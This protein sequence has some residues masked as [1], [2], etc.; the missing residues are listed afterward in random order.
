[1]EA[2]CRTAGEDAMPDD[3]TNVMV[4]LERIHV[5]NDED[6]LGKG[7]LYF[8]GDVDGIPIPR[9]Q[10]FER[11]SGEDIDLS[12][13]NWQKV[14]DVRNKDSFQLMLRGR[15]EDLI[16]D[17]ELG[18]VRATIR[19]NAAGEWPDGPD[20]RTST[21]PADFTLHY[22]VEP[23]LA[24]NPARPETAVI[25]R[26]HTTNPTCST[27]SG[28]SV[29]VLRIRA[30][31]PSTPA[32]TPRTSPPFVAGVANAWAAPTDL[33]FTSNKQLRR[34]P[35]TFT[36]TDFDPPD[37]LVLIRN[38]AVNP[39]GPIQLVADTQPAGVDVFFKAVRATDDHPTVGRDNQLPTIT[40]TGNN[41]ATLETNQRGSF[42]ILAFIDQNRNQERD[43]DEPGVY[44]PL[45][46]IE[47]T[48]PGGG[49]RCA[50]NP[51]LYGGPAG[52]RFDDVAN[53]VDAANYTRV[54][55]RCGDFASAA[56][57]GIAF[58]CEVLMVGGGPNGRRGTDCAFAG[59]SNTLHEMVREAEYSD[60]STVRHIVVDKVPGGVGAQGTITT[61]PAP[62]N[63]PAAPGAAPAADP[64]LIPP[65]WLDGNRASANDGGEG[66]AYS[67]PNSTDVEFPT[68][69]LLGVKYRAITAHDSPGFSAH[70]V[71]PNATGHA[72]A[73]LRT[74]VD[75]LVF[76]TN[77][78]AW[79]NTMGGYGEPSP[80]TANAVGFRT[81]SVIARVR[82]TQTGQWNLTHSGGQHHVRPA[83]GGSAPSLTA[84]PT[85]IFNP[86]RTP[87]AADMEARPPKALDYYARNAI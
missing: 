76:S 54:R 12:G 38:S 31:V 14:V 79:T 9:S 47:C 27:I 22:R 44:L 40:N 11:G 59:W 68:D 23:V 33:T 34:G 29:R 48:V 28:V 86:A 32:R 35:V 41:T 57:A 55:V 58:D 72:S 8:E 87:A 71:H 74:I 45:C 65:A 25:C 67:R 15:D 60:H 66:I 16:W 46:L 70:R 6:W 20:S 39:Q 13:P 75:R 26:Q 63:P 10:I 19:K 61:P 84:G 77:L 24:L 2:T 42:Y 17:D 64:V 83:T 1:M 49:D 30:T 53:R 82:W 81:Y 37:A 62:I 7:E 3:V 36:A 4:T 52:A 51:A 85:E 69:E 21:N 5:I 56:T 78:V 50:V 18:T 73:R 43:D 80:G